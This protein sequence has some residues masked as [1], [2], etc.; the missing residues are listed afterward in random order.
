M[1][2]KLCCGSLEPFAA[3]LTEVQ[4]RCAFG[5]NIQN[6]N[7][8]VFQQN[9]PEADKSEFSDHG[10]GGHGSL[11]LLFE[12]ESRSVAWRK[13]FSECF[14]LGAPVCFRRDQHHV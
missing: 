5:G 8:G 3:I 11:R 7:I 4:Q 12:F 1:G 10:L 13:E 9:K 2:L 14:Y 6:P